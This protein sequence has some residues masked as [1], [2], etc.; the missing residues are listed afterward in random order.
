MLKFTS[1]SSLL[2]REK[3]LW[4]ASYLGCEPSCQLFLLFNGQDV[5]FYR[6]F[7]IQL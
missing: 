5:M 4:G 2:I 6:L 3:L 7:K 1:V